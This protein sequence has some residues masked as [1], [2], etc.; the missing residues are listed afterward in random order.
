[1]TLADF[2]FPTERRRL[3][4]GRWWNITARTIH[5]AATGILLGGHAFGIPAERLWPYLW[6]AA[7]TGGALMLIELYPTGHWLHQ[8]CALAVYAK[9]GVLCLIPFFWNWRVTLLLLVLAI[10][11]VGAHAPRTLRHYSVLFKKVMAD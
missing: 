1:V 3:P 11:S 6:L 5:L 10:A 4:Y 7:G 8:G 9:L 2:I